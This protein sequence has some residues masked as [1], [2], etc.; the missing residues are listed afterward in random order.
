MVAWHTTD[1]TTVQFRPHPGQAAVLSSRARFVA[2]IAGTGGGKTA[3]GPLW[4]MGELQRWPGD[5]WM[6]LAPTYKILDRATIPTLIGMFRGTV[7]QGE[8]KRGA[9]YLPHNRHVGGGV[10]YCL[11]TEREEG[12]EGGQIRGAWLDEAGQMTH[13]AWIVVQARLGT[14]Q[15][16]A[17]LTTTPYAI[18]WLKKEFVDRY[19]RDRDPDY[20]VE[21]WPSIDNPAYP[22]AEYERMRRTLDARTFEMRY[23][24]KFRTVVGRI[25]SEFDSDYNLRPCFYDRDKA[26]IVGSDF[27]VD[28]MVWILCHRKE[29]RLEVFDELFLRDTTTRRTLDVLYGR[30]EGHRGGFQFYGDSAARQRHTAASESDYRQILNDERFQRLGR[31]VHYPKAAPA[32]MDRFAATN[33][34]LCSAS[35]ERR[36]FIDPKCTNLVSDLET[37]H[38]KLGTNDPDDSGDLGHATDALGYI[39]HR[40]WPIGIKVPVADRR[41]VVVIGR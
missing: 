14:K 20:F 31:T 17:L 25:F 27:N 13:Y 29:N 40:L 1:G 15:G 37:R 5:Q 35:D 33:A 26:I 11:S 32:R 10:I 8:Y 38:Y 16:R 4:L 7:F 36:L 3:T 12:L 21:C 41:N 18:N 30:Y 6:I 9:Y 28:P 2:A 39:I 23:M 19:A 24:A 34:M 22:T